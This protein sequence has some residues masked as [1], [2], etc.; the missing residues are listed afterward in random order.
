MRRPIM[1]GVT[2]SARALAEKTATLGDFDEGGELLKAV[3]LSA[4]HSEEPRGD[5]ESHPYEAQQPDEI[6]R[7][8]CLECHACS[9]VTRSISRF[10]ASWD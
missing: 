2:P 10:R 4:C 9:F 5:E 1:A 8:L 6:L 7:T 3:H